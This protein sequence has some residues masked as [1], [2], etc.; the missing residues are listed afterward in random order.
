MNIMCSEEEEQKEKTVSEVASV[1]SKR[2]YIILF[3]NDL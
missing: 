1:R 3:V 2:K